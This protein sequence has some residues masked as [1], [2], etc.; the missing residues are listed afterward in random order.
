MP[1]SHI[2]GDLSN[3]KLL[4]PRE[5]HARIKHVDFFSSKGNVHFQLRGQDSQKYTNDIIGLLTLKASELVG[6][7]KRLRITT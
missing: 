6:I 3:R 1:N 7:L 4:C 2:E 5:P